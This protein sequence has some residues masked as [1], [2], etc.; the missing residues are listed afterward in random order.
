VKDD[1]AINV[2][3]TAVGSGVGQSIVD[4]CRLSSLPL[5]LVGYDTSALAYGACD[6]QVQHLL[7]PSR[8][9]DYPD[10]LLAACRDHDVSIL[11]PGLDLDLPVLAENAPRFEAAGIRVLVGGIEFVRLC[12]DK[13][14]WSQT[15]SAVCRHI[16]PGFSPREAVDA[17]ASGQIAFPLIAKPS[18]GSATAGVR[19]VRAADDLGQLPEEY[20]VQPYAMPRID[21]PDHSVLCEAIS[22]R[23]LVQVSEISCQWL[24]SATGDVL[25]HMATRNRLKAGVPIEVVP[26]DDKPY[27]EALQPLIPL[28]LSYGMRGP[29]NI[30]GRMTAEGPRFF[31]MNGRFT[32]ISGLRAKL[33]FNEVDLAIRSFMNQPALPSR[34]AVNSRRIGLR[35]V[36]E[37]VV[38]V[39][40]R[41]DVEAVTSRRVPSLEPA[42]TRNVLVTGA[43]G[44]LGRHLVQA[45]L[46]HR[47]VGAVYAL[48]RSRDRAR[49]IWPR[50]DPRLRLWM[51]GEVE[52]RD[53]RFADVDAVFHLAAE[54]NPL[55]CAGH[56]QSLALT[57]LLCEAAIHYQHPRFIYLS[58]QSVYGA[59]LPTPWTERLPPAP[60]STYGMD[61]WAGEQMTAMVGRMS[62]ASRATSLRLARLYG[63]ADGLRWN[64]LPHKFLRAAMNGD[65]L[66]ILGGGQVFDL[67]HI[68]DA[69]RALLSLLENKSAAWEP[70][71]NVGGCAPV[72]ITRIAESAVAAAGHRGRTGACIDYKPM[73]AC[74]QSFG[75]DCSLFARDTEWQPAIALDQAMDELALMAETE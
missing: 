63:A 48:V 46:R 18:G 16:L 32:G 39:S 17:I 28:L 5:H 29:V 35:Q 58:S 55:D 7:P 10:V 13:R 66:T 20:V 21:D 45:L 44:W 75:M 53:S 26:I 27:W 68:R 15:L 61:K 25:G 33:G 73:N 22:Q 72:S 31:E 56:A 49:A 54:R 12:R 62:G 1:N 69:V 30:Q 51:A 47:S 57:R 42:T 74:G 52:N 3:I 11:I 4:S 24:I 60:E 41:P 37:R 23:R 36:A 71:Y 2:G 50:P 67:L 70:V 8:A 19:I 14:L 6:C 38:S 65:T 9:P 43:T 40:D 64:E 59:G 34:L